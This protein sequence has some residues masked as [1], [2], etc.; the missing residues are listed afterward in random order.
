[1]DI[2]NNK[3][4]NDKIREVLN[5]YVGSKVDED[6]IN[7]IGYEIKKFLEINAISFET[8]NLYTPKEKMDIGIL[9]INI[10][11]ELYPFSEILEVTKNNWQ[12]LCFSWE[13]GELIEKD[14]IKLFQY[15]IDEG[16]AWDLQGFYGRMAE[17]LIEAGYCTLSYKETVGR[18]IWG[19]VKIPSKNQLR[20]NAP[21]TDEYVQKR[22]ELSD[23]EFFEWSNLQINYEE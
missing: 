12:E 14:T 3:K 23:E 7:K 17:E 9:D 13:E 4:V 19:D 8:L 5:V 21:G 20:P 22:K 2:K 15:L 1:M 18:Y 11:N 10:D 6:L 16:H